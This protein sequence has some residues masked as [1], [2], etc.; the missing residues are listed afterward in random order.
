MKKNKIDDKCIKL[1]SVVKKNG[2]GEISEKY[3]KSID[4][5]TSQKEHKICNFILNKDFWGTWKIDLI[6]NN[7]DFNGVHFNQNK[8]LIKRLNALYESG[9]R[10]IKYSEL[11]E[12]NVFTSLNGVVIENILLSDGIGRSSML[13]GLFEVAEK[14]NY[15]SINLENPEKN[16]DGLW[17]DSAISV[18]KVLKVLHNY[19]FTK[20]E[21]T[22]TELELNKNLEVHFKKYFEN[23]K[24]SGT[25]NK[26]LIDLVI[27]SNTNFG[28][29]IKLSKEL[30][31]TGQSDRARGQI[32]KY[33]ELFK[34]NF[35]VI[36]AGISEDKKDKCI[37][38]IHR[39]IKD[40]G[41]TYYYM[42]P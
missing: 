40:C 15:F 18:D 7:C 26:G 21:I 28:I 33:M 2:F 3:L 6:D 20:E 8:P 16:I 22:L 12:F 23:V 37:Q 32:E 1:Q 11:S 39:K 14:G 27:G 36:I 29:E 25:S 42:E 35:L 24:K 41:A 34:T 10:K 5:D 31:K 30:K 19:S 4:I 17:I 9:V 38:D 13:L